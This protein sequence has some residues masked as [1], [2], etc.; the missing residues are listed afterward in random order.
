MNHGTVNGLL[1][2]FNG[3]LLQVLSVEE[4]DVWVRLLAGLASLVYALVSLLKHLSDKRLSDA[5]K[6]DEIKEFAA[7]AGTFVQAAAKN[8]TIRTALK[9]AW[10]AILRRR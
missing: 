2:V 9:N 7:E 6:A 1:V 8:P 5:Q 4:L 3:I 10:Y